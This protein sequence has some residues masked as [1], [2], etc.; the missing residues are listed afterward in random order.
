MGS[1]RPASFSLARSDGSL[2]G[3]CIAGLAGLAYL[4]AAQELLTSSSPRGPGHRNWCTGVAFL[5]CGALLPLLVGAQ[6]SYALT[7]AVVI[8]P[9]LPFCVLK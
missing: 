1:V 3:V 6:S 9:L 2:L 5:G 8:A 4:W 7:S